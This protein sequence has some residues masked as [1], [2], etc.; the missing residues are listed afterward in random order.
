[1]H[2]SL[3]GFKDLVFLSKKQQQIETLKKILDDKQS[4]SMFNEEEKNILFQTPNH[5]NISKRFPF[6][7]KFKHNKLLVSSKFYF[8]LKIFA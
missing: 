5:G 3:T 1:V 6:Y 8:K 2:L 4:Y 7:Y